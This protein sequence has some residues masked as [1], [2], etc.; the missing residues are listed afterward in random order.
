MGRYRKI[1]VKMWSDR[2]FNDLSPMKPSGQ[3]LWFFLL[4][5]PHTGPIPGLFRAGKA[6]MAEELG[7]SVE[8][9]DKAFEEVFEKGMAK[10]DF[11]SKLMWLPNAI[12]H[13]KPESPNVVLSW[14]KE[15]DMLP[16][17]ELKDEIL[18]ELKILIYKLGESFKKAFD[19]AFGEALRQAVAKTM[20]N[21]EQEQE[22]EQD[23]KRSCAEPKNLAST[24]QVESEEIIFIELISN[25]G[26][27]VTV[28]NSKVTELE[29]LFPAVDVRQELRNMAAWL[30]GSPKYRKTVNGMMKFVTNWLIKQQNKCGAIRQPRDHLGVD[31]RS[32]ANAMKAQA[33]G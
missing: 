5:G 30:D 31:D 21:Q 2:N 17:C 7:W 20:A 10:A 29:N 25:T 8:A 28:K 16:E 26:D 3:S 27:L 22:Q 19:K 14:G 32:W 33:G 13:N 11:K 6:A 18:Q 9:F 23:L 1:E 24:Q 15:F 12:K 4:T